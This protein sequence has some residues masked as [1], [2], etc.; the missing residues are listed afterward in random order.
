[1]NLAQLISQARQMASAAA[2]SGR[3]SVRV[4]IFSFEDWCE[5]YMQ[6][7]SGPALAAYRTQA[8][9]SWYLMR[10]LRE[11]DVEA[12]PVPVTAEEFYAWAEA[13]GHELTDSHSTAH[14]IGSYVNDP[15]TPPA[16]C[17]HTYPDIRLGPGESLAT[18]TVYGE[19]PQEPEVMTAVIHTADGRV[20]TALEIL[21]WDHSPQQAWE[22]TRAFLD[23][24]Q[25]RTVFHDQTIRPPQYCTACGALLVSVASAEDVMR[26][27][28]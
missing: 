1:M 21:A 6:P 17:M 11:M 9:R 13:T 12:V 25:P 2:A 8:K 23:R 18:L 20:I 10:F 3:R 26:D 5:L 19:S 22:K 15:A 7:R 24:H 14:A 4:P 28:S 27:N 16:R